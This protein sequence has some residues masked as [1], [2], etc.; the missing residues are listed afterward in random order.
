VHTIKDIHKDYLEHVED[1][2]ETRLFKQLCEEFNMQVI[3]MI[4]DGKEFSMGSNL[5][6]LSVMRI[7]RN[8]SRPTIDWWESNKYK[9]ELLSQGKELYNAETKKGEK[10]F[11]YYTDPWYCKYHW[12]KS[13]CKIS[14]KSAYRFTPTRG[15][16]GNKE[17]LTKLLKDNEIAYLRF[18]KHGNI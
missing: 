3:D 5:S 17:K 16:K 8:P 14:N 4:L 6:S 12:K 7:E 18:K 15:I 2:I 13:K 9:Q 11:I 10:W 1:P